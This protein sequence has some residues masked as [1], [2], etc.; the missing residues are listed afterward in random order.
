MGADK[1]AVDEFENATNSANAA[2]IVT[3][4]AVFDS[5]ATLPPDFTPGMTH[6]TDTG[7]QTDDNDS[8]IEVVHAWLNRLTDL[9]SFMIVDDDMHQRWWSI[10]IVKRLQQ[11]FLES[12]VKRE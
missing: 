7:A 2:D 3:A 10:V 9:A 4:A 11:H 8:Q 12:R 1:L 6:N 5:M